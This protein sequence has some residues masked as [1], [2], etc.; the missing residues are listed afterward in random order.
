MI[1]ALRWRKL[2]FLLLCTLAL[3]TCKGSSQYPSSISQDYI[4]TEFTIED[5]LPDNTV[6]AITQTANGL[7]WIGTESGLATFDGRTFTTVRLRI[8]GAPPPGAVNS[9]LEGLDGDLWVGTDAGVVRILKADLNDPTLAASSAYLVGEQQSDEIE[10]LFKARDGTIWAGTNHG[11][12][13]FDGSRFVCV[14]QSVYV[15]RI[16]QGLDGNLFVVTGAGFVEYDGHRVIEHRGIGKQFGIPDKGIFDVWQD[17]QGTIW[18]CTMNGIRPVGLKAPRSLSPL[19]VAQTAAFQMY[20]DSTNTS[21]LA[22]GIGVYRV[23][24]DHLQSPEPKLH[25]RAFYPSKDGDLWLGTNG[26]GLIHFHPRLVHMY[27]KADG[28]QSSTVMAVLSA[29]DGRLWVGTNCGLAKF[30]GHRLETFAEKDGLTNSCVWALA[31]DRKD[32]IWIG[33][34]GGGI[35][36]YSDGR[37]IQYTI[38]Q[39]LPS[40]IVFQ[41]TVARD[42]SLWI[43][44]PDGLSHMKDSQFVNYTMADG[45]SSN[46]ILDTHQD[47]AGNIWISTQG[48]VNRFD[49]NNHF[50]R[51]GTNHETVDLLARRFAEDSLGN[52]YMTDAPSGVTWLH[53]NQL[54]LRDSSLNL[55]N[56]VEGRDG[57]LWFSSRGGVVGLARDSLAQSAQTGIPINYEQIDRADG[58]I[59]TEASAGSP[60]IAMTRNGQLWVATVKGLAMIDVLRI[61][62]KGRKPELFVAD[63]STDDVRDR[64]GNELVLSP[65]LHHVDLTI[66]AVDLATP[67]KIRLQYRMDGVDSDWLDAS[68]SRKAVY[69]NVPVGTHRLLVRATD[70]LGNWGAPQKIYEVTQRP[71]FYQTPVFQLSAIAASIGL[72]VILYLV[73]VRYLMTQTSAMLEERQVERE[74]VARDLHDTFLQGIQGLILRFHTGTQQLPGDHPVRRNFEEALRQSDS[75]ML[76]G[77]SVL[78]RLRTRRATP[79]SLSEYYG[80][81]SRELGSLSSASFNV[82]ISG[83]IRELNSVVQEELGKIGREALFNAYRHAHASEI[84]VEFQFGLVELSVR[85]RDNGVGLDP[86]ILRQ[87]SIPGHFGLPGMRE[88]VSKI[89]G[90]MRLWSRTG[91]GTELEVRI[92]GAIAYGTL[93]ARGRL[94]RTRHRFMKRAL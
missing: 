34:Y 82:V 13:H 84:E 6:D 74:S 10:V 60:N 50:T 94:E 76:E 41:I 79:S 42:D 44:T 67:Q 72:L 26:E 23:T 77:R 2:W 29:H 20:A 32:N 90:R 4:R 18:Y 15:S 24:G 81:V 53:S 12:Y 88:R 17:A 64:V 33:T 91:A 59:T 25:T 36:R 70:N 93:G 45:L 83:R 62:S 54:T 5:G 7:L 37:F 49:S 9:L 22:T 69:T 21:W 38:E 30:D 75:V 73:R 78:S 39:G 11:L 47:R 57:M 35:F 63:A 55:M 52:L 28:L 27:T 51:V 87:G 65:G 8:P 58:L 43:A 56:M 68:S 66:A 3:Q 80:D 46:R 89:G 61:P 92:P 40:R 19:Q 86:A 85:F 14:L 31:E 48:G 16:H 1:G 71:Y